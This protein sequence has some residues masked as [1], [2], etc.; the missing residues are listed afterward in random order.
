[1]LVAACRVAS[2][3][4]VT[5]VDCFNKCLKTIE[6][7]HVTVTFVSVKAFR[8][9]HNLRLILTASRLIAMHWLYLT[10]AIVSEVAGT[11]CMKLSA[12]FT[13]MVPSVLMWVFYGICFYFLTLTLKKVDV[14]IAY[15][16]WSGVGTVLIATVGIL[17]FREPVGLLK[18]AG[19][20]AII[21]G[22]IALN[23]SGK[24]TE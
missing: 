10:L 11:T 12:G 6:R 1:M 16:I 3:A 7:N 8:L 18:V 5:T 21:G 2:D 4:C 13:K 19:I 17:Y 9:L 24:L 22:V 23:I 15:A 20:I 14:G